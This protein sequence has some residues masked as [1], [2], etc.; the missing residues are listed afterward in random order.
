MAS[1]APHYIS[2]I[3]DFC[4]RLLYTI[5]IILE[6]WVMFMLAIE[7]PEWR[8]TQRWISLSVT[9]I[10]SLILTHSWTVNSHRSAIN[11]STVWNVSRDKFF[12]V[13][14]SGV[15]V[16]WNICLSVALFLGN[17]R[18]LSYAVIIKNYF[19][20]KNSWTLLPRQ[21]CMLHMDAKHCFKITHVWLV[22]V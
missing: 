21:L 13:T 15:P 16:T 22:L 6:S 5:T 9:T 2:L 4:F 19:P 20:M 17:N 12:L 8:S 14:L 18:P 11:H 3:L 7:N 10:Q 1:L